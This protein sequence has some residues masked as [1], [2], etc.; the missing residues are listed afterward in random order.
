MFLIFYIK[1]ERLRTLQC[2]TKLQMKSYLYKQIISGAEFY[3][4]F[5]DRFNSSDCSVSG[6]GS[7]ISSLAKEQ[8]KT[9]SR[10]FLEAAVRRCSSIYV[11]LKI[12]QNS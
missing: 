11:L 4:D 7:Y 2:I 12:L 6:A 3:K 9:C 8:I 10:F 5:K 1:N